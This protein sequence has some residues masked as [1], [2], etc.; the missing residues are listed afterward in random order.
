MRAARPRQ[1]VK[2]V[3]VFAAPA[4]GGV[5]GHSD[6]L[7]RCIAA[8][9]AFCL[10]S[11]A[12]YILND[13][14]DVEADRMHPVKRFRPI[15]AGPR[16]HPRGD[17]RGDRPAGRRAR[18]GLRRLLAAR[19]AAHGLQGAD[20]GVYVPAQAHADRRH[21]GG[22]LRLHRARDRRRSGGGRRALRLVPRRDLVRLAVHGGRQAPRRAADARLERHAAGAGRLHARAPAVRRLHDGRGDDRHLLPVGVRPPADELDPLVGPVDHPVRGR[23]HA[24]RPTGRPRAGRRA[25]G[26]HAARPGDADDR[27]ALARAVPRDRST[28]T[29]AACSSSAG[30]PASSVP[31]G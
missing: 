11:S 5:L 31:A 19:I 30:R 27:R 1:W 25:G 7:W 17:Q 10:V 18:G 13:L 8:F 22:G 2:N 3:L 6:V 24:L 29:S 9:V 15:A 16:V 21:R 26:D 12:T 23:D 20:H 4:A 28:S 14:G